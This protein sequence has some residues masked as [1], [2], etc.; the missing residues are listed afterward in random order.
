M[1]IRSDNLEPGFFYHIF[2]RGINGEKVFL[3]DDN[4]L[5]FLRK[6]SLYLLPVAELYAYCLMPNHFHLMIRI[7]EGLEDNF[8][9]VPNFGKVEQGLHAEKSMASKQLAK[10]ISSYTQAFNKYHNRHGS[11]F[12][13]PFK[14]K[15]ITSEDYL[16]K[17]IVYIHRNPVNI[18]ENIEEYRFS[19]YRRIVS[20]SKT[21]VQT[22]EVLTLFETVDNFKYLHRFEN[23]YEI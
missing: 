15:R 3:N 7:K 2:N 10:L 13:R 6:V 19:S 12:E 21:A 5:F 1:D 22:D 14:R 18:G 17:A 11:I 20:D 8:A 9:K 4:R 16:R 23:N